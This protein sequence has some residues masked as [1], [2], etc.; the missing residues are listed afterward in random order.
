MGQVDAWEKLLDQLLA[1]LPLHERVGGDHADVTGRLHIMAIDRQLE[2]S[3]DERHHK[4]VLAMAG[5]EA[6]AVSLVEGTIL[7]RDVRWIAHD[8]MVLLA[9][10]SIQVHQILRPIG[11]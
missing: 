8:H 9:E 7:D 3:F 2:K 10:N 4:R 6:A 5:R 1:K 11:M